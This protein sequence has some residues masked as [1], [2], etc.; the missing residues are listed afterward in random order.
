MSTEVILILLAFVCEVVGLVGCLL[1]ILPGPPIAC[2]GIILLQ[3]AKGCFSVP[4]LIGMI[5]LAIV[6]TVLYYVIPSA[7]TKKFGGSKLGAWCC[8]L[9]TIAGLFMFPPLG[10]IVMPFVGALVGELL[11]GTNLNESLRAATGALLGF[12]GSTMMK[13]VLC[14]AYIVISIIKVV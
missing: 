11:N 5:I 6:V 9:G 7:G 10:I 2:V 1:P 8:F 3:V 13:A 14:I 4:F 12:L